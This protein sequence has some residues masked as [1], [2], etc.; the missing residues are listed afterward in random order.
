[1]FWHKAGHG[2][3]MLTGNELQQFGEI[4][5]ELMKD[6]VTFNN[7]T[8]NEL[9]GLI[10]ET[11]LQI[12]K[13]KPLQRQR[14]IDKQIVEL[15]KQLIGEVKCETFIIPITNLIL[16]SRQLK[17][18]NVRLF[19]FTD[20]HARHWES[21]IYDAS[22]RY[23]LKARKKHREDLRKNVLEKLKG[24][25]CAEVKVTAKHRRGLEV[26]L[27]QVR[28]ALSAIIMF[29]PEDIR[30]PPIGV[31]GEVFAVA[32]PESHRNILSVSSDK[33]IQLNS[34]YV[35]SLYELN[36][37]KKR[38]EWMVKNGFRAISIPLA[39]QR[40]NSFEGRLK[41]AIYWFGAAMN[42]PVTRSQEEMD[43]RIS[44]TGDRKSRGQKSHEDFEFPE[45][46]ER[47]IKLMMALE[48]LVILDDREPVVSNLSERTAFL[49]ADKLSDRI[50]VSHRIEELYRLRSRC[51]H[52]GRIEIT[53]SELY[54]LSRVVQE[55]ILRLITDRNQMG[56]AND[57]EFRNWLVASKF[58]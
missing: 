12:V 13:T 30:K 34:E 58:S 38:I 28:L 46:A 1:M 18:G 24:S 50:Y 27:Q 52:H 2:S 41:T 7:F 45:I 6:D 19:R 54:W 14:E 10:Q 44:L 47:L 26:A 42:I 11:I 36:L 49:V 43:V 35:G 8:M 17:V 4:V 33:S 15:R 57:D 29:F 3:V 56:V 51:I 23:S 25:V 40:S 48:S 37:H 31:K 32:S 5:R 21:L 20:T 39:G 9:E 53:Y 55:A 16:E 22:S